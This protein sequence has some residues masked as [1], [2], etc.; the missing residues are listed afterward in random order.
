MLEQ[1][2]GFVGEQLFHAQGSGFRRVVAVHEHDGRALGR[3]GLLGQFLRDVRLG[4]DGVVEDEDALRADAL[5]EEVDDERVE[6]GPDALLVLPGVVVGLEVV[7]GEAFAVFGEGLGGV[8]RPAVVDGD[9]VRVVAGLVDVLRGVGFVEVEL[10]QFGLDV[11]GV[12]EGR[13]GLGLGLGGHFGEVI[14]VTVNAGG[15]DV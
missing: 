3:V 2:V 11:F 5:F 9:V 7:H 12:V 6:F 8:A 4:P 10:G 15:G 14:E 13:V 1:L